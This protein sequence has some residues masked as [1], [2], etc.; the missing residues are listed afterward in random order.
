MRWKR[1]DGTPQ[2]VEKMPVIIVS[3][4]PVCLLLT[5]LT[6]SPVSL[7]FFWGDFVPGVKQNSIM[8]P[9]FIG[10]NLNT[11]FVI[12][13][14][15]QHCA[16][17]I[18]FITIISRNKLQFQLKLCPDLVILARTFILGLVAVD[19]KTYDLFAPPPWVATSQTRLSRPLADSS[20]MN[21]SSIPSRFL[22]STT[23]S[24]LSTATNETTYPRPLRPLKAEAV[25]AL[26][27]ETAP[28]H[29][30]VCHLFLI[31]S[32][33]QLSVSLSL[34]QSLGPDHIMTDLLYMKGPCP[35]VLSLS[36]PSSL[37]FISLLHRVGGGGTTLKEGL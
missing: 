19:I 30:S 31:S 15:P 35:C 22:N 24:R 33:I 28:S 7:D 14:N 9:R 4:S 2:L 27:E 18:Y 21:S 3:Q 12:I 11:D 32:L 29:A 26:V 23:P 10:T 20:F 36:P 1:G 6:G 25:G 34:F 17:N 5:L 37:A 13:L 16:V 8:K